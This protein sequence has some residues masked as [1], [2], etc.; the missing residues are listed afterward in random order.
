MPLV[1]HS[2]TEKTT[3][4]NSLAAH[5]PE[6]QSATVTHTGEISPAALSETA[7]RGR[8]R[9][10]SNDTRILPLNIDHR[11]SSPPS[12]AELAAIKL[13]LR[14]PSL[15]ANCVVLWPE[16]ALSVAAEIAGSFV[17]I[18]GRPPIPLPLVV[19]GPD[20]NTWRD[21]AIHTLRLCNPVPS[22]EDLGINPAAYD[23][24]EHPTLGE[25]MRAI[26]HDFTANLVDLLQETR[27]PLSL[28]VVFVSESRNAGVL[29]QLTSASRFGLFDANALIDATPSSR[30]GVWWAARRGLLTQTILKLNARGYC[31]PP[32]A[33]TS[34]LRRFG[35]A[36]T[37]QVLSD[38][39]TQ[40]RGPARIR[41]YLE[42]TDLGRYLTGQSSATSEGRGRPPE[43]ALQAIR[44]LAQAGF[45][46][47]RDKSL[48]HAMLDGLT[49]LLADDSQYTNFR[50]ETKLD[51]AELIPDNAIDR[52]DETV[53]LEYTWR[54]G[55][56]LTTTNRSGVAI[57]VL[58]KLRNYCTALGW[59]AA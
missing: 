49:A 9:L 36:A 55:D 47:G 1:A 53:C 33:S 48:N 57:Y 7:R 46:A 21:I 32:T 51:F 44:L 35:S 14:A 11:E 8:E 43:E 27:R 24:A 29:A 54:T 42:K 41:E 26:S 38:A 52:G 25:F 37:Q 22:V 45:T 39:G 5:L 56:F 10:K 34:L 59:V 3:L 6:Y 50:A 20:R 2:G 12:P 40:D 16:T 18:A 31:L 58:E 15:G 30:I 23:P 28:A 19:H 17:Q 13:F 4:A